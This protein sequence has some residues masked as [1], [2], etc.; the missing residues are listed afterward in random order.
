M[1]ERERGRTGDVGHVLTRKEPIRCIRT[2]FRSHRLDGQRQPPSEYQLEPCYLNKMM[3]IQ[4][5]VAQKKKHA[6]RNNEENDSRIHKVMKVAG[7]SGHY[8]LS[9][10]RWERGAG[11][12]RGPYPGTWSPKNKTKGIGAGAGSC[13]VRSGMFQEGRRY[14]IL[15]AHQA[16][17]APIR[18]RR[19]CTVA[20]AEA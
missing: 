4:Q 7:L 16:G 8:Q 12:P 15:S 10:V 19:Y 2:L 11:R 18:F 5:P 17:S 1:K 14:R 9:R 20:P 6:T 3:R 13:K